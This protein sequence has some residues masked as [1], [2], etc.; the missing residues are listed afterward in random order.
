MNRKDVRAQIQNTGIIASVRVPSA[1]DAQFAAETLAHAGLP[2]V[3]I[4]LAIPGALD[5]IAG[6]ASH[7]RPAIA[8]AG[9]ILDTDMARR[10]VEAGAKFLVTDGF[11]PEVVDFANRKNVAVISGAL[12]PTEVIA[13]WKAGSDLVKVVPVAA[14]GGENYIRALRTPFPQIPLMAAGGVN[15]QTAAG[16]ISA[17][18]TALGIG[19]AL[20]PWEAVA[21]HQGR[22]ISELARRFAKFV[23]TARKE[24]GA[25][26][27]LAPA[28]IATPAAVLEPA[29]RA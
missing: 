5:V 17:G 16:F 21:L 19:Q 2:V 20:L 29:V 4:A 15:Q 27:E 18:A 11:I 1:E 25:K 14:V 3:E 12:T 10:A 26:L 23:A 9:G 8:G 24:S 7:S 13:A 6:L 28:K 22:R